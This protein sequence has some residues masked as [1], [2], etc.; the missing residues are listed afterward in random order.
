MILF[1]EGC[2]QYSESDFKISATARQ[3]LICGQPGDKLIFKDSRS[4]MDTFQLT[5]IDST[6]YIPSY[7]GLMSHAPYK[8]IVI[9]FK[10]LNIG[11]T[12]S[13]E[14]EQVPVYP[15]PD[16][17]DIGISFSHTHTFHYHSMRDSI[18]SLKLDSIRIDNV[19]LKECKDLKSDMN[20]VKFNKE[21]VDSLY[22]TH[23]YCAKKYGIVAYKC[24]NGDMWRRINLP[25]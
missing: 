22:I 7:F 4:L 19:L 10:D 5:A 25:N 14:V 18:S 8:R 2:N 17:E 1:L 24:R 23:I 6:T 12:G 20:N 9:R 15:V 3:Y 11:D 13:I 21:V 16:Q